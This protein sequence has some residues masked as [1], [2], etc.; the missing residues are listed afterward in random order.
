MHPLKL[1]LDSLVWPFEHWF[2]L[3]LLIGLSVGLYVHLSVGTTQFAFMLPAIFAIRPA[4]Q[5]SFVLGVLRKVLFHEMAAIAF[6][7]RSHKW[8]E[9][10]KGKKNLKKLAKWSD[11]HNNGG[12]YAFDSWLKV[13]IESFVFLQIA[14]SLRRFVNLDVGK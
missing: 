3:C 2:S 8:T 7:S 13:T 4:L 9:H 1:I 5:R 11:S 14:Y 10:G 6:L 12:F